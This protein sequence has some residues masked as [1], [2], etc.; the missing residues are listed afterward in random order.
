M[1]QSPLHC[2]E[3]GRV[4]ERIAAGLLETNVIMEP[5]P[6]VT[7]P[8]K[9][10]PLT[11]HSCSTHLIIMRISC[12]VICTCVGGKGPAISIVIWQLARKHKPQDN[13][14]LTLA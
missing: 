6:L 10:L 5:T 2:C 4:L 8:P 11:T 9:P 13:H 1:N 12:L 7:N 3:F 14:S